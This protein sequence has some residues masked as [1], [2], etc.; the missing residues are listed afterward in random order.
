[1]PFHGAHLTWSDDSQR[2]EDAIMEANRE[3]GGL[4][5]LRRRLDGVQE[6]IDAAS[7]SVEEWNVL[8]RI[9]LQVEHRAE[10]EA[11][12]RGAERATA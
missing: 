6:R 12:A 1:M 5:A 4:R 9:R 10:A 8:Y 7:L 2:F 3:P 11:G